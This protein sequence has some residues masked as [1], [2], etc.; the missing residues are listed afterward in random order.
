LSSDSTQHEKNVAAKSYR[1]NI[2]SIT[3]AVRAAKKQV[4][5]LEPADRKKRQTDDALAALVAELLE[6]VSGALNNIIATLGLGTY[7]IAIPVIDT[8]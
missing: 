3:A 8:C 2:K 6:E 1:Q 7:T 5:T 4:D